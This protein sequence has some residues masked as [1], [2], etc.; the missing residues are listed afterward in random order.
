MIKNNEIRARSSPYSSPIIL[1]KKKDKS[2]RLCVDFRSLNDLTIKNRFPIPVIEDL[3]DEL[4]GDTIFSKLDLCSGY[5]QIR[6]QPEDVHKAT[7]STHLGHYEF[8]VMPFGLSNA[9]ATF[10]E[11]MNSILS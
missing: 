7:F 10:Q 2:W 3:L 1:V 4:Y 6:M 5:H 8:M 11:L 9:P